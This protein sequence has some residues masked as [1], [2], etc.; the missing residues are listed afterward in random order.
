[1][2]KEIDMIDEEI[3]NIL[4]SRMK[5]ARE[6]GLYKKEN[7]MTILQSERWKEVLSKFVSRGTQN[8]LGEEFI[9]RVIKSIHDESIEQQE[10]VLTCLLYTSR[11]V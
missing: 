4:A 3:M 9:T 6:I 10:R 1:M 5:I 8:G 11:C 2:R 7:N